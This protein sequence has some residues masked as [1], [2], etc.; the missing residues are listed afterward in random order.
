MNCKNVHNKLIFFVEEALPEA[1][2]Q[3]VS[4]HLKSCTGCALFADDMR[5]T[6]SILESEKTPELNPFFYTRVKAKLEKQEGQES[7]QRPVLVRVLQPLAFS[8][9]LLFGIYAGIK[10]GATNAKRGPSLTAQ[11]EIIPYLNEMDVEPLENFLMQ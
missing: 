11:Q 3:A 2:M 6:L 9:V 8:I 7:V 4:A 1:E 5:K 10:I